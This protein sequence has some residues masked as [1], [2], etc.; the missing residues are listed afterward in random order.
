M[1]WENREGLITLGFKMSGVEKRFEEWA[2]EA[3]TVMKYIVLDRIDRGEFLGG[4]WQNL[5]YSRN[6]IKAYKLGWVN[7]QDNAMTIGGI[8]I[9]RDD[10]YW[11]G[12]SEDGDF[13]WSN[14]RKIP[15][16]TWSPRSE[17]PS[18][19]NYSRPAPVFIPGYRG[20]RL[21]YLGLGNQRP[22]LELT[23]MM[24]EGFGI[25]ITRDVG[26]NQYQTRV[27][28]EF[29]IEQSFKDVAQLTDY[30]R[31]WIDITDEELQEAIQEVGEFFVDK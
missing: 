8:G 29:N 31:Q 30:Y 23:G 26:S 16:P 17:S 6:A 13:I 28:A 15:K 18:G 19:Q 3:S 22:N 25:D 27:Q 7:V 14:R 21:K 20:W 9:D 24:K 1:G 11:G 12:Y 4:S 2:E 10:W 5:D